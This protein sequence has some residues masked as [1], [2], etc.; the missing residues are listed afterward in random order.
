MQSNKTIKNIL[1]TC[2]ILFPLFSC[3][4]SDLSH[5]MKNSCL[6]CSYDSISTKKSSP[7]GKAEQRKLEPQQAEPKAKPTLLEAIFRYIFP[8][9]D[10]SLKDHPEP[11]IEAT[12]EA[13]AG[14]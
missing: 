11:P 5:Y 9:P 8:L 4:Q 12:P 1:Y 6:N 14:S 7:K 3:S 13:E 10:V 2:F